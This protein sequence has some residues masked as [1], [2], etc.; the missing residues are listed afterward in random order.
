MMLYT[1]STTRSGWDQRCQLFD[2]AVLWRCFG[3]EFPM[4]LSLLGQNGSLAELCRCLLSTPP[5]I[6]I[7]FRV[8]MCG[9]P[10]RNSHEPTRSKFQFRDQSRQNF[11]KL[12]SVL[13]LREKNMNTDK[14][15][16]V[17]QIQS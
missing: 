11:R 17:P 2:I 14:E 7:I 15:F 1:V 12:V 5:I 8:G 4:Y 3:F 13:N 10:H 9:C 16:N 6:D